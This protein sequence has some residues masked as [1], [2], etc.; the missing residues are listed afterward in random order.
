MFELIEEMG[1]SYEEEYEKDI[2]EIKQLGFTPEWA[3]NGKVKDSDLIL[4]LPFFH[5]PCLGARVLVRSY[6]RR[7]L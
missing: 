2:R 5:R 7:Y 3:F 4:P 1:R 6:V